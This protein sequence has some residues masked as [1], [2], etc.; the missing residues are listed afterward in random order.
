MVVFHQKSFSNLRLANETNI[1]KILV[2]F[3]PKRIF[4]NKLK[5]HF[6]VVFQ[7]KE[8]FSNQHKIGVLDVNKNYEK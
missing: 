3:Q 6:M 2:V 5:I 8:T 1:D 4:S 7:Q